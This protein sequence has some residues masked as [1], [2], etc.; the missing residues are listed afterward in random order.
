MSDAV[1]DTAAA[2]AGR[3]TVSPSTLVAAAIFAAL[4]VAGFLGGGFLTA[5]LVKAMLLAIA[6]LSLDLLIGRGGLVSFGHA[7]FVAIGAYATGIGLEEGI[8]N[9]LVLLALALAAC[10]VF[11]LVTGAI[12]LRT[13][14]VGFIM[15]TLAFGQMAFFTFSSL[16]AYGGDDGLTLWNVPELFGTGWLS[17]RGGLYFVI[18]AALV[19]VWW[20]VARIAASRFGRV[21]AAAKD[22]PVR[23]ATMG[24]DVWRVRLVA[25]VIAGTLAG[26]AGFL[27]ACHAEFVS[28]AAAA[29]QQSGVLIVVVVL[30]GIATR[31]GALIGAFA[32]VLIEEGL[33]HVVTDWRLVFGPLL[34][35]IVLFSTGGIGG[36]VERIRGWA[37]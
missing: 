8:G 17:N 24:Y 33:S 25:Y 16:A 21:L 32:L 3:P 6:A 36:A 11:A 14:G 28:P 4:L 13:H 20:L 15:I 29:W 37:R 1:L 26:L 22:N 35:A 19:L 9:G 34:V 12:S 27:S 10:A 18:L 23:V 5:L 31:N 2:G 30:G 7:A